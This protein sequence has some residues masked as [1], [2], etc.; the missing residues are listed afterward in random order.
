M[1]GTLLL[2]GRTQALVEDYVPEGEMLEGLV[3][4]FSIFAD[5]TRLRILS[6]L[7]IT[8]MCVTDISRVLGINQTTVSHQLRYLKNVG[9]VKASRFGKVIFYSLK[10]D[11]VNDVLLKGVEFLGY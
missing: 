1:E 4:F 9:I 7:A 6:A 11:T 10:N 2:D 8:E 5:G 3:G